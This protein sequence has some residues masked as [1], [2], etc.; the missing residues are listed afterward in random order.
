MYEEGLLTG[1]R[2]AVNDNINVNGFCTTAGT[3]ALE[4]YRP[5]EDAVVVGKLKDAGAIV[6]GSIN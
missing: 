2:I 3:K 4:N 5:T 1:F 6:I